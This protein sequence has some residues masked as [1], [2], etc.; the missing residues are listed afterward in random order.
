MEPRAGGASLQ[1]ILLVC[2]N[3]GNRLKFPRFA[4]RKFPTNPHEVL[5][6]APAGAEPNAVFWR[7][8]G[9][10]E[11]G[12]TESGRRR[13]LSI[14][15]IRSQGIVRCGGF[16]RIMVELAVLFPEIRVPLT[17]PVIQ[18]IVEDGA[19]NLAPPPRSSR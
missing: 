3:R 15:K 6:V 13:I 8:L 7:V 11:A 16:P 4:S 2:D 19:A 17:E 12:A 1:P 14:Q 9:A 18:P 10:V 5:S